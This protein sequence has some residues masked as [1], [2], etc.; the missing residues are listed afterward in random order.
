MKASAQVIQQSKEM[1]SAFFQAS[2]AA[3]TVM[4]KLFHKQTSN[5]G[6]IYM[7]EWN[8]E[9]SFHGQSYELCREH[10]DG[11]CFPFLRTASTV[12]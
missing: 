1:L 10:A 4:H 3:R 2:I 11:E 12:I 5:S 7:F 9:A 6:C 8:S